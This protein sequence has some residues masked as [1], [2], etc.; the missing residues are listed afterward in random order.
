MVR[1]S[2]FILSTVEMNSGLQEML[3]T[4]ILSLPF[5]TLDVYV[6]RACLSHRTGAYPEET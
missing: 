5:M 3:T 2:E 6:T 1:V 4:Q